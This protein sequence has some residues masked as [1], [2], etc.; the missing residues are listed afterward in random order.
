MK[1]AVAQQRLD[2]GALEGSAVDHLPAPAG[3][4][5]VE[6]DHHVDMGAV[7]AAPA[8]VLVVQEEPAQVHQGV[9]SP[10]GG[11]AGRLSLHVVASRQPQGGGQHGASLGVEVA[12]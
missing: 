4:Q 10:L 3:Q 5:V 6:V 8:V 12:V 2:A 11:G 9:G 1:R 7:P